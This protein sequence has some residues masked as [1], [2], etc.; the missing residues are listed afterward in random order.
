[1]HKTVYMLTSVLLITLILASISQCKELELIIVNEDIDVI[2]EVYEGETFLV[3]VTDKDNPSQPLDN[4]TV[5]F[6]GETYYFDRSDP[7]YPF[8]Y[9]TAP[10]VSSDRKMQIVVRKEGYEDAYVEIIVKNKAKLF[11]YPSTFSVKSGDEITVEVRDE[12]GNT[13]KDVDVKLE[14]EGKEIFSKTNASGIAVLKAPDVDTKTVAY[15]EVSKEGYESAKIDG[16]ISP[17]QGSLLDKLNSRNF[18]IAIGIALSI[19]FFF[20]GTIRYIQR[21]EEIQ[22]TC[23]ENINEEKPVE[24]E[25]KP[26]RSI[27]DSKPVSKERIEIEEII[28]GEPKK[29]G[30]KRIATAK[31]ETSPI[32][33]RPSK[34][35]AKPDTW[36]IGGDSIIEKIDKKL[37]K[38]EG[39]EKDLTRWLTGKED[40]AAK[41]DEKLK[42][43][44]KKKKSNSP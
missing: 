20:A 18:F 4:Y 14:I 25:G 7:N 28:V 39:K 22:E 33:F 31:P 44:E 34:P 12:N 26:L 40:I 19:I 8:C 5:M 11:I 6:N 41:V 2:N 21:K 17:S 36:V 15:I 30:G 27:E 35:K 37:G 1:M 16:F 13:V 9:L 42:E 32:S 43:I 24:F 3:Y 23:E 38:I 10:Q 29:E